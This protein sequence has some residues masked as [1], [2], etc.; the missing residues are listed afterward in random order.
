MWNFL[1]ILTS[2]NIENFEI[3]IASSHFRSL[4]IP[5]AVLSSPNFISLR[6]LAFLYTGFSPFYLSF[7]F[8]V[9]YFLFTFL[10]ISI[11]EVLHIQKTPLTKYQFWCFTLLFTILIFIIFVSV[12]R[13]VS[14]DHALRQWPTIR[15]M[16]K[17]T[18]LLEFL[19]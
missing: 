15:Y 10:F 12:H 4:H 17:H 6:L 5:V 14:I 2:K 11:R 1:A 8:Q 9:T 3:K 7:K 19:A 18:F 16:R 13:L